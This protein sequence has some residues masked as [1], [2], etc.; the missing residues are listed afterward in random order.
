MKQKNINRIINLIREMMVANAPGSS[1]GFG[2]KSPDEGPT[3]GFSPKM[4]FVK[5]KRY[6]YQKN[7]RKNWK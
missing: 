2:E 6:I 4:G 5:R 1:G 7:T 3:A